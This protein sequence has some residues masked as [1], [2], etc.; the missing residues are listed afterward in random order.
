MRKLFLPVAALILLAFT[1][2]GISADAGGSRAYYRPA[3][4]T[5]VEKVQNKEIALEGRTRLKLEIQDGNI[6]LTPWDG[7]SLQVKEI[8]RLKAPGSRK[9]LESYMSGFTTEYPDNSYEIS[10][11]T[12]QPEK[13]RPFSRVTTDFELKVPEEVKTLTIKAINGTIELSGFKDLTTAGLEL[14]TGTIRAEGSKAYKFELSVERGDIKVEGLEGKGSFEILY[15]NAELKDIKGDIQ[16]KS[17]SGRT[18]LARIEGKADCDISRGSLNLSGSFL[19]A[20]SSLY[21][22]NGDISADISGLDKAGVYSFMTAAGT[23]KLSIPE[24][25]NFDLKAR[26]ENGRACSGR[27]R[28]F[29]QGWRRRSGDKHLYRQGRCAPGRRGPLDI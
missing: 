11:S 29:G 24:A 9:S 7:D 13:L 5:T 6:T 17:T 22:S 21:A 15:G 19:K 20:G 27:P 1:A 2:C 10:I 14:K 3:V 18:D 8:K 28:A 4:G 12:G 26:S 23:I 25:S 16:V